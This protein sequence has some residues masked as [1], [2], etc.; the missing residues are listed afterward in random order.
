MSKVVHVVIKEDAFVPV[1]EIEG[2]KDIVGYL[3][4]CHIVDDGL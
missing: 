3:E 2:G 4:D 1:E